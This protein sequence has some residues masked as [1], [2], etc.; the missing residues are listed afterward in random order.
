MYTYIFIYYIYMYI[1]TFKIIYRNLS[2]NMRKC[3]L[4]LCKAG[5]YGTWIHWFDYGISRNSAGFLVKLSVLMQCSNHLR[6]IHPYW[7]S[8]SQTARS[9]QIKLVSL[10]HSAPIRI[11]MDLIMVYIKKQCRFLSQTWTVLTQCML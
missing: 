4:N 9:L 11:L 1:N 6:K 2:H 10:S 3:G 8:I 7:S 5:R